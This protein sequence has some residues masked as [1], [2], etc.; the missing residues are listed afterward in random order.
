MT[1]VGV[2]QTPFWGFIGEWTSCVVNCSPYVAC[3][4][5]VFLSDRESARRIFGRVLGVPRH[6][7]CV[8]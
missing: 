5:C 6:D 7:T 2:L 1:G 3:S 8:H 4:S